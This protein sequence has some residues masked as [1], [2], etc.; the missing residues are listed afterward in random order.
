MY[1]FGPNYEKRTL[2]GYKLSSD[3]EI[4]D[5]GCE[6]TLQAQSMTS[7]TEKTLAE[8]EI[9]TAEAKGEYLFVLTFTPAMPVYYPPMRLKVALCSG[10]NEVQRTV[11]C[12][13]TRT[14]APAVDDYRR[15]TG[16][17]PA[18]VGA[19][20][21]D[22]DGVVKMRRSLTSYQGSVWLMSSWTVYKIS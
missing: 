9:F 10:N 13:S 12:D 2:H 19:L 22:K 11:F 17:F 14:S 4:V 6:M 8:I 5:S 16:G 3:M 18:V 20:N 1:G 7:W 15:R 21:V